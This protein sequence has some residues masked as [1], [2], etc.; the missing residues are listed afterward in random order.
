MRKGVKGGRISL[1]FSL[2]FGFFGFFPPYFSFVCGSVFYISLFPYFIYPP[3]INLFAF[4][5]FRL[6]LWFSRMTS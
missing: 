2:F 4:L 5:P 1:R 3:T 6:F